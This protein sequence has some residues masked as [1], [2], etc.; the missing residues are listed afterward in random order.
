[1]NQ[2]EELKNQVADLSGQVA[3]LTAAMPDSQKSQA[4]LQSEVDAAIEALRQYPEYVEWQIAHDE[5]Q[6]ARVNNG[7][8]TALEKLW[9][10]LDTE[11][12]ARVDWNAIQK[13]MI[14]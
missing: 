13:R 8:K 9:K 11:R 3:R 6:T 2:I 14:H 1:M 5:L 4:A 7:S 12:L 10:A